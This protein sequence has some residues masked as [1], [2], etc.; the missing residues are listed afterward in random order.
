MLINSVEFGT[1]FL[2]KWSETIIYDY[3]KRSADQNRL[4]N[5][6][7]HVL[8]YYLDKYELKLIYHESQI[9]FLISDQIRRYLDA[10]IDFEHL[11]HQHF[12]YFSDVVEYVLKFELVMKQ[13]RSEFKNNLPRNYKINQIL[14]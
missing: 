4:G 1:D 6:G 12:Q 8:S 10:K 3:N 2:N 7:V 13:L 11:T 14:E 9:H 5:K